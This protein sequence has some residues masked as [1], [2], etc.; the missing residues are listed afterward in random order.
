MAIKQIDINQFLEL[1][2][3]FPIIDVRSPA[4]FAHAHIPSAYSL[5]LFS[6]EERKVV[7]TAYKQVSREEAIKIGLEYFGPKMRGMV[8]EAEKIQQISSQKTLLVHCWRGGM[9][10]SAVAWLLSM[11]GFDIY[12][13]RGGYK[14]Y[15]NWV[16]DQF[17]QEYP[18]MVLGGYTGSGKTEILHELKTNG[19]LVIDLEDL[20]G[21]RGSAFG[22]LGLPAQ[23]TIEHF[24]NKL[25]THLFQLLPL[26]NEQK[27]L[28]WIEDESQRIGDV[29]LPN[30]VF[31]NMRRSPFLFIEIPYELRLKHILKHYGVFDKELLGNS[32]QRIRKR[33][34]GL[35]TQQAMKLLEEDNIENC[36]EILL[37]YYDR[38]YKNCSQKDSRKKE[39]R[40]W[41]I[42][43][44]S[45][46]AKELVQ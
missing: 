1:S 29:N 35:E 24:E 28:I 21:H 25:A 20:A 16:L 42:H 18:F 17:T 34:G 39:V 2:N 9:R 37:H 45:Q 32:I 38:F 36:F 41:S 19:E 27:K 22:K 26:A 12:T 7:G 14:A 15:R 23:P 8:E 43:Q 44:P 11:Y 46:I 5:P 13:L 33:L 31:A 40:S 10:S 6:D 4:E 3:Q 30:A